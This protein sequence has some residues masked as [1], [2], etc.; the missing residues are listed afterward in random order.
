MKA[1]Y[2]LLLTAVMLSMC[3][4]ANQGAGTGE[5]AEVQVEFAPSFLEA[6][7]QADATGRPVFAYFSSQS[8]GYCRLFETEVLADPEVGKALE[9]F[10]AARIDI[11]KEPEIAGSMGVTGTP[12]MVFLKLHRVEGTNRTS[13]EEVGRLVGYVSK[14]RFLEALE[15]AAG[16]TSAPA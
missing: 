9:G 11:D 8:C 12:T 14:E 2:F 5:G 3:T 10:V 7:A 16:G 6:M 15:E 4:G 1:V 13:A